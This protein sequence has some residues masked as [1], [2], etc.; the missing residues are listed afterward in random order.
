MIK[1]TCPHC[2]KH[3]SLEEGHTSWRCPECGEFLFIEMQE[4]KDVINKR[5]TDKDSQTAE[6][7]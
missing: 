3:I 1:T 5:Q 7:D 6:N 2:D 4:K